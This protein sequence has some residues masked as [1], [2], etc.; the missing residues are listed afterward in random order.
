MIELTV[1][2]D[3]A[4]QR[5]DRFLRKLLPEA[6]LA[7]IHRLVRTGAVRVGG[8]RCDGSRRLAPGDAVSLALD[9][10]RFAALRGGERAPR[11]PRPTRPAPAAVR[12][13]HRDADLWIVDKPAG[14]AVHGGTGQ[15]DDLAAR[16]RALAAGD[17]AAAALTF[18]PAPAHRLDRGTSGVVAFGVSARGLRAFVA[19]LR[20]GRVDKRYLAIT[21]RAPSPAAGVIDAPLAVADA[22]GDRPKARTAVDGLLARTTYRTLAIGAT[23]LA[24]VEVR[25]DT[26]RTHQIR[27]HLA[28]RGCPLVGDHRYGAL[29]DPRLPPGRIA[30]HAARLSFPHPAD[31]RPCVVESPLPPISAGSTPPSPT[32]PTDRPPGA[33]PHAHVERPSPRAARSAARRARRRARA[34]PGTRAARALVR[35]ARAGARR[36]ARRH[37]RAA[38][39]PRRRRRRRTGSVD[40]LVRAGRRRRCGCARTAAAGGDERHARGP[41]PAG[42]RARHAVRA[43]V[44]RARREAGRRPTAVPVHA[45]RRPERERR[46]P[47]HLGRQHPRVAHPDRTRRPRLSTGRPLPDPAHRRRPARPLAPRASPGR[48]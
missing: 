19:A 29:R 2:D 26:G 23:G 25:L 41:R 36:P 10:A 45:R 9:D 16:V 22:G 39:R 5:L 40:R 13:L 44:A 27:A 24:L 46:R 28:S 15:R 20:D 31:G 12:V 21:T 33:N 7:L 1:H 38:A 3:D 35:R 37:R 11:P 34:G 4:G 32:R 18:R 6:P 8:A 42:R 47:A 17:T 48:V 30:L 14:L 43:A